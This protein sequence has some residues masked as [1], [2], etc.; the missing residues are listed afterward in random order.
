MFCLRLTAAGKRPLTLTLSPAYRGEGTHFSPVIE[1]VS[2]HSIKTGLSIT[3]K[4][5]S[6]ASLRTPKPSH[7]AILLKS[8]VSPFVFSTLTTPRRS[9]A[10]TLKTTHPAPLSPPSFERAPIHPFT[11][12]EI[13]CVSFSEHDG[14]FR[15]ETISLIRSFISNSTASDVEQLG[16]MQ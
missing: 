11:Q 13:L 3:R 5:N 9:E 14:S 10:T 4:T 1:L 8:S 15:C 12:D 2:R 7:P 16:L 6:T